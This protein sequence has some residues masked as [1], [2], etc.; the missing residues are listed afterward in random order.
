MAIDLS[1]S[2]SP[3]ATSE[4]LLEMVVESGLLSQEVLRP[5]V[6]I[7]TSDQ[8]EG[9]VALANQLVKDRLLTPF[10][11]RQILAGKIRGYFLGEKY[12]VLSLI[13]T[14]GTGHVFLCEQLV[15]Q[16]LV[17]VKLLQRGAADM[18]QGGQTAAVE[19]FIREA[20]AVAALNHPNIVRIHDMEL[21]GSIPFM[22][23]EYVDGTSLHQIVVESLP[24]PVERAIHYMSQA[25]SGL[26]HAH[27]HGLIHRDIKPGNL[28]LDRSGTVKVLDMG[29]AR[30][31]RSTSRNDNLTARYNDQSVVGTVDYMSPEQ[32]INSPM[33]D[34]RSDIYSLGATF[35]FLLAGRAPFE[36]YPVAQ[37]LVAHQLHEP[38]PIALVRPDVPG[39]IA[40]VLARMLAKNTNER[41]QTPAEVVTALSAWTQVPVPAPD[42]SEMPRLRPSSYRL[43]L[44]SSP[45]SAPSGA[46]QAI[47]LQ[48]D[49]PLSPEGSN[50]NDETPPVPEE[51]TERRV[52]EPQPVSLADPKPVGPEPT[53]PIPSDESAPHARPIAST[54]NTTLKPILVGTAAGFVIILAVVI[55]LWPTVSHKRNPNP[56]PITPTVEGAVVSSATKNI[57]MA[58]SGST[59]IKPAM[60]YWASLYEQKT[61]VKIKYDGIGSGNGVTNMIEKV[62]DFG[63]TDAYLTDEQIIKAQKNGDI[64]HI[65]L[66]MGAVVATYNLPGIGKQLRFTGPVLADIYLGKIKN[67]N[68]EAIQAC[69]PVV[70]LPDRSITVIHR[71]ESS[72]TTF[73]WT[74]YLSEVSIE[75]KDKIGKGTTVRWPLGEDADKNDGVARAVSLKDGALGYVELSFALE[76]NLKVAQVKNSEGR[77][78]HPSLQ[79]VTSAATASLEKIPEDL[80]Y[81]LTNP[82]GDGSYSIAGSTW[83][84]LYRNQPGTKGK[85]LVNFLRWA[86]H[87]GQDHL[88]DM[89]YAPLPRNLVQRIEDKLSTIRTDN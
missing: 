67:W 57:T 80:R 40:E 18:T 36:G 29:L 22:V 13:G 58:G 87:E 28:L 25:A 27:E 68:H 46:S 63:C 51:P 3:P 64:V 26:Q 78:I 1:M 2:I 81:T 10:Q 76:R 53:A 32:A 21:T 50:S 9:H 71:S 15:L 75:W 85:E 5:Y 37:K 88:A 20:R 89:R 14:G 61:G 49:F 73:I 19:R 74:D 60:E 8:P 30:F 23:M 39:E 70:N 31:L 62:L 44:S 52:A 47:R 11:G 43:G 55:W 7:A 72:G 12:K 17:A 45:L 84:V 35:Y 24:F 4:R 69:N 56:G 86:V 34:I 83:L 41:Y 59:A 6:H 54:T 38:K 48:W 77:Y 16:R 79:S 82:P 42:A 33:L 65:P 66:V